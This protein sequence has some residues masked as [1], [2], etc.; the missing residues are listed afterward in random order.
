MVSISD[1]GTYYSG[2][3]FTYDRLGRLKGSGCYRFVTFNPSK[4]WVEIQVSGSKT[5]W[6][7]KSKV[8][9]VIEK[10]KKAV[11][12]KK[13]VEKVEVEAALPMPTQ[14]K[15]TSRS[16]DPNENLSDSFDVPDEKPKPPP[17]LPS[18]N[19][20]PQDSGVSTV[21]VTNN[22]YITEKD[23]LLRSQPD[24]NAGI[25]QL[26]PPGTKLFI[27][28]RIPNS[29]W[30]KVVTPGEQIGWIILKIPESISRESS[31]TDLDQENADLM[32]KG[33]VASQ[34]VNLGNTQLKPGWYLLIGS[35]VLIPD[36]LFRSTQDKPTPIRNYRLGSKTAAFRFA[37]EYL[38]SSEMILSFV[39]D[40][41]FVKSITA[42]CTQINKCNTAAPQ[43]GAMPGTT[44]TDDW[45]IK[46]EN[47]LTEMI[48]GVSP[49]IRFLFPMGKENS[50]FFSLMGGYEYRLDWISLT[51]NLFLFGSYTMHNFIGGIELWFRAGKNGQLGFL[52]NGIY[53]FLTE[54]PDPQSLMKVK[55]GTPSAAIGGKGELVYKK[56]LSDSNSLFFSG[57]IWYLQNTFVGISEY[58]PSISKANNTMRTIE[59][60]IGYQ[61]ML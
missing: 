28:G 16:I 44:V 10:P 30:A 24:A 37:L 47:G 27:A 46:P 26:I 8:V 36:R 20:S 39:A 40:G 2:P 56:I 11:A 3:G 17:S 6:M 53:G 49:Q 13:K 14:P 51:K 34:A 38:K 25:I 31:T 32:S 48:L 33:E 58:D 41:G 9:F 61:F 52:G 21:P 59:G 15:S 42:A 29:V 4:D 19:F 57:S 18:H 12:I 22:E 5:G 50:S 45:E 55:T 54:K 60:L 1:G 43:A 23:T 35:G 7:P